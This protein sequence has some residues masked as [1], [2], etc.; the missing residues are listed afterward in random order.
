LQ[1]K[2]TEL[3]QNRFELF[4]CT[5]HCT[6]LSLPFKYVFY[7][8][9]LVPVA[10]VAELVRYLSGGCTFNTVSMSWLQ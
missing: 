9:L 3:K 4:H 6:S 1:S 10:V 8:I 5:L 2:G 7:V